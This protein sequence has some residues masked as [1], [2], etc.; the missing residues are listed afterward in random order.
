M[1]NIQNTD[2]NECFKWRLVWYLHPADRNPVRITKADKDFSKK[3]DFRDMKF[4][5]KFRDM[6]KIEKKNISTLM[7]FVM[8]IKKNTQSMYQKMLWR[9]TCWFMIYRRRMPQALCSY[10]RF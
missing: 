6:H 4:S 7:S 3:L 2:D 10:Q 5:V 1:I 9:Q 8:K